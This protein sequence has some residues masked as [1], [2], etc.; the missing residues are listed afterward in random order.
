MNGMTRCVTLFVCHLSHS[1]WLWDPHDSINPYFIHLNDW[2]MFPLGLNYILLIWYGWMGFEL[3]LSFSYCKLWKYCEHL[4]TFDS[5]LLVI[6][7]FTVWGTAKLFLRST[8]IHTNHCTKCRFF[9]SWA[10]LVTFHIFNY[11]HHRE[12]EPVSCDFDVCF[13]NCLCAC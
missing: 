9:T 4:F 7:C 1:M 2:I 6:L 13:P 8:T 11:G 10:T 3:F 5:L 12:N